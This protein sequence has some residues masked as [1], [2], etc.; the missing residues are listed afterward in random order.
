MSDRE[1]S[2]Y[3]LEVSESADAEADAVYLWMSQNLGP[4]KAERWYRGLWEACENLLLFPRMGQS[5]PGQDETA[6]LL[7]Y[8]RYRVLYRIVES[9]G[10]IRVLRIVHAGRSAPDAAS[11]DEGT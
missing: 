5:V 6:R 1:P 3:R 8:D 11:T 2:R 10:L 9:E 4:I 7:L